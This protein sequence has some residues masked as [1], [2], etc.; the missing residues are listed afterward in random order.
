LLSARSPGRF[1]T[2]AI[3][4]PAIA[5]DWRPVEFLLDTG[6]DRSCIHPHDAKRRFGLEPD[7]L[8]RGAGRGPTVQ[9]GGVGGS[10]AD[11]DID[12]IFGFV[13]ADGREQHI[14]SRVLLAEATPG[15]ER[16]PSLLGWDVLRHFHIEIDSRSLM[17]QLRTD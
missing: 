17:V 13:H 2:L 4:A 8:R 5:R 7:Q 9:P 14:V 1:V 11:F 15:N 6:A 3:L 12:A 10:A 16:F